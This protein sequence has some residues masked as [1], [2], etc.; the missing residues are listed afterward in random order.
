MSLDYWPADCKE[1]GKTK[2]LYA[3][4]EW[5]AWVT[6]SFAVSTAA[7]YTHHSKVIICG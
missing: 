5:V 7:T 2:R 3:H 4:L 6:G 1:G